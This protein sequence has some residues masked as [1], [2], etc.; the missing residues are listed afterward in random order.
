MWNPKAESCRTERE[1]HQTSHIL[2]WQGLVRRGQERRVFLADAMTLNN[3]IPIFEA[4]Y[5]VFYNALMTIYLI[6]M[7]TYREMSMDVGS[8]ILGWSNQPPTVLN[9]RKQPL[10]HP[11]LFHLFFNNQILSFW[12]PLAFPVIS[13][14]YTIQVIRCADDQS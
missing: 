3:F 4:N 8:L 5:W 9:F 7:K 14:A 1:K 6:A 11:P 13:L 2:C 10:P 12:L